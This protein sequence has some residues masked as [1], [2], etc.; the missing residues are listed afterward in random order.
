[1]PEPVPRGGEETSQDRLTTLEASVLEQLATLHPDRLTT[2]EL[3]LSMGSRCGRSAF[4]DALAGLRCSGLVRQN[5]DIV[6]LT[7]AALCA[8]EL[9]T[10]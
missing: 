5:G 7:Y 3:A 4:D 8:H 1:M 10:L 2:D 6:E 9:L